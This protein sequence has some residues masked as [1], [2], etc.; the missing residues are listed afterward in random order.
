MKSRSAHTKVH[1]AIKEGTLPRL[2]QGD[3]LCVDCGAIAVEYDHRDYQKPLEVEPVCRKCNAKRGHA[4]GFTS[5]LDEMPVR[6]A[7]DYYVCSRCRHEWYRR[8]SSEPKRC[9][10]CRSEKWQQGQQAIAV[11]VN[12]D[13]AR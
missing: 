5:H 9:P 2:G 10:R 7:A 13:C 6:T 8:K 4:N 12:S 1:E 11:S 3:I